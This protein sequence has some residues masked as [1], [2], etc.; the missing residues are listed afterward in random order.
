MSTGLKFRNITAS[1][2]DPVEA[3]PFEGILAAVER[4]TLPDWRRLARAI[5]ADPWG[6]V[7]RQVLEAVHISRPY[8]TTE[9]LE[10]VVSRAR[11]LA[12]DSERAEVGTEIRSL[13][14]RSGL[15]QQ[16]F[17]DRIGTSRSRLST[18]LSG[19][20]VPSAALLV[21]MRR[22]TGHTSGTVA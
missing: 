4:G 19:K 22:V 21:R 14:D 1:P 17:A 12:A 15:S 18:Y 5:E 20:V 16:D 9:L 6:L 3:W 7:A 13:L 2:D 11:E 10:G 8:G